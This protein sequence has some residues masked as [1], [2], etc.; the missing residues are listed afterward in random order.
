MN[1]TAAIHVAKKQLGLDEDT[2]RD[3][4]VR[5][6]GKNSLRDMSE[7]ERQSVVSE[8]RDRGF[9]TAPKGLEGPFAKKLQALWIG[10]WN[11]GIVRDKTDAAMLAFVK[12]QTNIDHTRF[13]LNAEDA[14][15]AVEALKSWMAR[16]GGVDWTEGMHLPAWLRCAGAKIAV[17]QWNK[18]AQAGDMKPSIQSFREQVAEASG[19]AVDT[20]VEG[21]WRIVMNV[22]GARV[23]GL[24]S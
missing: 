11:L 17:A 8:L 4:L 9:K 19:K 3:V 2:Y 10:A 24:K 21:D 6:T 20:M 12:R 23:R 7:G 18:L 13:L 15:K 22:L 5:V 1:S 16:E 14:R